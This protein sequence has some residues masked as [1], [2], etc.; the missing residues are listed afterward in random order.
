LA[1]NE[2]ST[3][4][5]V[6]AANRQAAMNGERWGQLEQWIRL[7]PEDVVQNEPVLLLTRA[8]LPLAYGFDYD[9]EPL[10]TRA[11]SLLASLPADSPEVQ[12]L[13]AELAYFS[14]LGALM[15]GPAATAIDAGEKMKEALPA[16][17]Y[18]LGGQALGLEAFGYQMAGNIKQGVD[19]TKKALRSGDWPVK[20]LV[21]A[22]YNLTL[23]HF[24]EADLS[25]AQI[26]ADKSIQ[27]ALKHN[28][29]ASDTRCFVGMTFYLQNDLTSAEAQ[30]LQ[31]MANP[32]RVDPITL[33]HSACTLKR[34]YYAQGKAEKARAI[35][36]Q[37]RSQLEELD[38]AFSLQLFDMFQVELALDRGYIAHARQLILPLNVSLQLPIWFWH[39]YIPQLTPIKLWLAEGEEVDRALA[40]LM[41]MD[42]FLRKLNRNIHRIDI[43][44]LQALA[45]KSL[46]NWPKALEKL[47]QSVA[48][49]A[50]G[51]LIRNYLNLGANMRELLA[52]LVRQKD[53]DHRI[54]GPTIARILDAFSME[55]PE[56][57]QSP[58]PAAVSVD[59]LTEREREVLKFLAT[60]LSTREIAEEMNV[61]WS[62]IRTH[63]KNIYSKLGVHGRYEAVIQAKELNLL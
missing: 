4:L 26:M 25:S 17:A 43:L 2:P 51:K 36:Q 18:Y 23:L 46:N 59:P 30:F 22:F 56:D 47:A 24:M 34:L 61:A 49:A 20:S 1:A 14:G 21:K 58:S 33:I 16:D 63:I 29:D 48:L 50:R 7:F 41:E 9:L 31:V 32:A 52:Q 60:D 27:L 39:Y 6:F 57:G 5:A 15:M 28:L 37:T 55:N 3:A 54:D 44:A 42:E 40:L 19:L 62:T 38:N 10:L 12:K 53:L 45:Y 35:R 13:W 11:G 8:H